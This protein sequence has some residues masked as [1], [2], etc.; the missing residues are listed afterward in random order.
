MSWLAVWGYVSLA[1]FVIGS[2]IRAWRY[3]RMPLHVRWELYPV[4]HEKG[5]AA[6]GGSYFEEPDW[7]TKPRA[8]S[9]R[10]ELATLAAEVLTLSTVR[11]NN[12]SL[13][14]PSLLFHWGLYL[15]FALGAALLLGAMVRRFGFPRL[16]WLAGG[17]VL[18]MLGLLAL[19][20]AT[21]GGC[22]LL[23]RR[24][25]DR[26][27]RNASTPADF[28]HLG[29]LLAVFLVSWGSWLFTDRH[30][31]LAAAFLDGLASGRDATDPSFWLVAQVLLLGVFLAYLPWSQMVHMFAKYFTWH[32]V[33]WD[34][35]PNLPGTPHDA[36]V[37]RLVQRPVSWAAPHIAGERQRSWADVLAP[38][39]GDD[40]G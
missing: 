30:Y 31:R 9:V 35:A 4:A 40:R 18:S 15:L 38:E 39:R 14:V 19:A 20:A 7:W 1:G 25:R 3:W 33:R 27:L 17:E 12:R 32:S 8:T 29:L 22:G 28:L 13:W 36:E 16:T 10:G 5:K 24:L 34:D 2:L 6:Y 21:M 23:A 11:R 37:Q 26:A